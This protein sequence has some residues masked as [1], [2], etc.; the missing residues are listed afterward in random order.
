LTSGILFNEFLQICRDQIDSDDTSSL[1]ICCLEFVSHWY[2]IR[3]QFL[4]S[5]LY[6]QNQLELE[7]KIFHKHPH[8]AFSLWF[9]GLI[10]QRMKECHLALGYFNR[11]MNILESFHPKEHIDIQQLE[12]SISQTKQLMNIENLSKIEN[13]TTNQRIQY[14]RNQYNPQLLEMSFHID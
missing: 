5:L 12:K 1:I 14:N 3:D 8:V 7:W 4:E 6:R 9:I 13:T 2:F 11:A 10:F